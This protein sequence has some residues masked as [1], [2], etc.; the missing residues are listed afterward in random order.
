MSIKQK[1]ELVIHRTYVKNGQIWFRY[2]LIDENGEGV[3]N[4]FL[5]LSDLTSGTNYVLY[6]S[7]FAIQKNQDYEVDQDQENEPKESNFEE[8]SLDLGTGT[9]S[10]TNEELVVP[11]IPDLSHYHDNV[12]FPTLNEKKNRFGDQ[13][14]GEVIDE[15]TK[16][17]SDE[18]TS[19]NIGDG[20][21]AGSFTDEDV[22][23]IE[24][25]NEKLKELNQ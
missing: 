19:E 10:P 20:D 5:P 18:P 12:T 13:A 4:Q 21:F 3:K 6:Q 16:D 15:E 14:S 1:Y 22:N 7:R 9:V 2:S 11:K 8:H 25:G 23:A 17:D 24:Y